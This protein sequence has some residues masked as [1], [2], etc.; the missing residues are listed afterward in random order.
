[1]RSSPY[2]LSTHDRFLHLKILAHYVEP[3]GSELLPPSH[4]T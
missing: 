2:P 3:L 4:N 1:M